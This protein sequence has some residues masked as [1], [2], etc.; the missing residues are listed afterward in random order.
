ML[1]LATVGAVAPAAVAKAIV[2]VSTNKGDGR[3]AA[4]R[5]QPQPRAVAR[6]DGAA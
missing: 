3:S 6:R 5:L 4:F 2:P 1:G